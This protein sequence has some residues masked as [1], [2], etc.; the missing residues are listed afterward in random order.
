ME[1]ISK[2][3]REERIQEKIK[4]CKE[5]FKYKQSQITYLSTNLSHI[6]LLNKITKI[7]VTKCFYLK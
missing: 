2:A 1:I 4:P 6:F 3:M 7:M 5:L